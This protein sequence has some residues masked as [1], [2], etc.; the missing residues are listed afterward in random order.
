[1]LGLYV[2]SLVLGG[3][4]LF[5]SMM[6]G[7]MGGAEFDGI[8]L[9]TD[10]SLDLADASLA[11]DSGFAAH[12]FGGEK[13]PAGDMHGFKI[14]SMR[15]ATYFL[16]GFGAAGT[17]LTWIGTAE[18]G[19]LTF[20]IAVTLG[21]ASAFIVAGVFG[22]LSGSE[23]GT[24]SLAGTLVGLP[25]RVIVPLPSSGVGKVMVRH[26]DRS[27]DVMARP[28]DP[29]AEGAESWTAVVIVEMEG[30]IALVAPLEEDLS[31]GAETG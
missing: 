2:F 3:G 25:G 26:R 14:V 29:V 21:L 16:F 17:L 22:Y 23:S 5:V 12:E 6:G 10:G 15:T 20:G 11:A 27:V 28:F 30:G 18:R 8:E 1:M 19:L 31:E 4:L 24:G 7:I 9:E 13:G